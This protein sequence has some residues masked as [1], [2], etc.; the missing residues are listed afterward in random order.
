[1]NSRNPALDAIARVFVE[2]GVRATLMGDLKSALPHEHRFF[3]DNCPGP[4]FAARDVM[5][6]A[7]TNFPFLFTSEQIATPEKGLDRLVYLARGV[8][9]AMNEDVLVR[10]GVIINM[11]PWLAGERPPV[12]QVRWHQIIRDCLL[13]AIEMGQLPVVWEDSRSMADHHAFL[14]VAQYAGIKNAL[15]HSDEMALLPAYIEEF[16]SMFLRNLNLPDEDRERFL[17][18]TYPDNTI[19]ES[20]RA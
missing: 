5:R 1:M 19:P 12:P 2:R 7:F 15:L 17:A 6:A 13:Q 10:A 3:L 8:A 20:A 4:E 9:R 18:A 14:F 16:L 11:E